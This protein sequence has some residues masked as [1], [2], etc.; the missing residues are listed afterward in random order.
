MR[1]TP[2]VMVDDKAFR[3]LRKDDLAMLLA[4]AIVG[5]P[6]KHSGRFMNLSADAHSQD[7]GTGGELGRVWKIFSTNA[8]RTPVVGMGVGVDG[9]EKVEG[10]EREMDFQ[11][12]FVEGECSSYA[13]LWLG[14]G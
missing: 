14:D 6:G 7:E 11:S 1:A 5:L 10:W 4:Q 13:C 3:G 8:F 9:V 2:A 12:S